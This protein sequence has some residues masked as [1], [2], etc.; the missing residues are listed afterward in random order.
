MHKHQHP[1]HNEQSA[2]LE[3]ITLAHKP[4]II[5]IT[6]T[7]LHPDV[8]DSEILP[9]G[10]EVFRKD[11]NY[12]GGGVAIMFKNTLRATRLTDIAGVECVLAKFFLND[13]NL[14]IGD[15]Y[16]PPNT[17]NTFIEKSNAFLCPYRNRLCNIL[18][19][20]DFNFPCISW[21]ND[22]PCALS[23][24]SEAFAYFVLFHDFSQLVKQPTRI[25]NSTESILDMLLV[26][27]QALR[28]KPQ[29]HI[30]EGISDH[31][32]VCLTPQKICFSH[33]E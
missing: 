10:C 18:L 17:N 5:I 20:G 1:Q 11:R 16:R 15:F 29:I 22:F 26:N 6:E 30:F 23:A 28:Q 3:S 31:K 13:C 4:H 32:M 24:F 27:M 8:S 12:R 9:P 25:Q 14:L 19:A 33:K 21:D 2:D 7:W